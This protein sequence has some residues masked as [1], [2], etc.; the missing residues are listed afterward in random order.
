MLI[1]TLI[2]LISCKALSFINK[3]LSS[4]FYIRIS[5]LILLY[6]SFLNYNTLDLSEIFKSGIGI[7]GGLY[8]VSQT[9]Q[10]M[11]LFLFIVSF[12][13]LTS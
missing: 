13:I 8:H 10:I 5:T 6:C 1:F 9:T 7:Y 2:I 4:H 12:L 11:E 3:Y